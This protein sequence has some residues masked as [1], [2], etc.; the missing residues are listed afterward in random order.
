MTEQQSTKTVRTASACV[1]TTKNG[2][3]PNGTKRE[4]S[5]AM[6]AALNAVGQMNKTPR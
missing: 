6:K 5:P 2:K 3:N 4:Y 1:K